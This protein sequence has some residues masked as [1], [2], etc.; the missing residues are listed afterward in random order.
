[1]SLAWNLA[2]LFE[3]VADTAPG[4]LALAHDPEGTT[5]TWAELD[6][7]TDALARHLHAAHRPGDKLA[8]YSHNRPEFVEALVG[9]MK[10]RLAPVNVNYRY[11]DEELAYLLDNSDSTAV[12]YESA[13]AENVARLRDRLPGVREW[14]EVGEGGPVNDFALG[15]EELASGPG[16]RL[17][18]ERSPDDLVLLY[19]GGT[20]G[21]P[22]GVMWTHSA[23]FR[24]LG[25]GGNAALGEAPSESV[26]EQRERIA[27]EERAMRLLPACPL[28]HG[29]GQFTAYN[30]LAG[31]GAI[32]TC[33]SRSLDPER[34]WRTVEARRVRAMAIV[35]DAFAKP[36][37]RVL[38]E[39]PGRFGLSSL[40]L[41]VSSGVM[42]SPAVKQG[43]LAHIPLAVLLDSFGSSEAVGF[44]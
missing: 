41:V 18:V 2:D 38:E 22:K 7:R 32:V 30:A 9:A 5:R 11:R 19:T 16:G 29:T 21:M 20:T 37:L 1:M 34:L 39:Q 4:R 23:L 13:F 12:V 14:I 40:A 26:E 27:V 25:G 17:D 6:R 10:A 31:G 35:G 43:L 24:A 44:G 33:E 8:I 42:W 28:M 3:L 15:F 36:L